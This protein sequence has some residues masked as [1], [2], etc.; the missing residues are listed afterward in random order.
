M[1]E[2]D[3]VGDLKK[4]IKKKIPDA[5]KSDANKLKLYLAK[6]NGKWLKDDDP[7]K[8]QLRNGIVTEDIK[9]MMHES[10]E[11]MATMTLRRWIY[12]I[13]KMQEPQTE[14]IHV[15]VVIPKQEE[16]I[17][18]NSAVRTLKKLK[19]QNVF[20]ILTLGFFQD[21]PVI[22]QEFQLD[23]FNAKQKTDKP[24]VITT[25]LNKF[26]EDYGG[27]PS[28]YFIRREEVMFWKIFKK[29]LPTVHQESIVILGSPG[30]GK[31]CFLMLVG[32]YMAFVEKKKV[33]IVRYLPRDK[34]KNSVVYLDGQGS[35]ARKLNVVSLDVLAIRKDRKLQDVFLLIDGFTDKVKMSFEDLIFLL[36]H[37]SMTRKVM[38]LQSGWVYRRGGAMICDSMHVQVIG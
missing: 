35:F 13:C 2:D 12:G 37:V 8:E 3:L 38:N 14:E 27:F 19:T 1:N 4:S 9:V 15:L 7:A 22:E 16:S 6:E 28:L 34:G 30:I 10:E 5:V 18:D 17:S 33:L 24:F 26:W 20:S 21:H 29:L 36:R 25:G 32:F 23:A 11:M 31:S